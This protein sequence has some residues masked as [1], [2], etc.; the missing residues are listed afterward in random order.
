MVQL[1]VKSI[2]KKFAHQGDVFV[3]DEI[4]HLLGDRAHPGS[5]I[6]ITGSRETW[7]KIKIDNS[8]SNDSISMTLQPD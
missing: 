8:L 5:I 6:S 7:A 4:L 1:R 2:D 3:N